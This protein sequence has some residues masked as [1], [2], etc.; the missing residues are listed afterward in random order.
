VSV[1]FQLRIFNL[2]AGCFQPESNIKHPPSNDQEGV[3]PPEL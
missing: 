1:S 3:C 2:I